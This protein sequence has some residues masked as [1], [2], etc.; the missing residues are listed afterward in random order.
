VSRH[1]PFV[2][3]LDADDRRLLESTARRLTASLRD[4]QRARI[5]LAAAGGLENVEIA[6]RVGVDVNTVSKWRK[7]FFDDGID[8]LSDRHRS[9]RP[10]T[11]PPSG[12]RW[13]MMRFAGDASRGSHSLAQHSSSAALRDARAW[14]KSVRFAQFPLAGIIRWKAAHESTS[15]CEHL[16]HAGRG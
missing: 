7:R 10:R 16:L 3:M 9:G 4:V 14:H 2:I 13:A 1:S 15:T 11:F 8:G 6:E 5:V 12:D